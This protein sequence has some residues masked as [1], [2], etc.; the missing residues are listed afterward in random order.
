MEL[1]HK[2]AFLCLSSDSLLIVPYGIETTFFS[3]NRLT[4]GYLLIVP[5]GIETLNILR[6]TI[7]LSLLLI[8]PYGIETDK[9]GPET[10]GV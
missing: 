2:A 10:A 6:C 1:K 5:Y 4:L 3:G 8:V 9:R 7:I